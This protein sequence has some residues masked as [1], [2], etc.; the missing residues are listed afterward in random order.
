MEKFVGIELRNVLFEGEEYKSIYVD[1]ES[2]QLYY[3]ETDF[4][5][6]NQVFFQ[7]CEYLENHG[8]DVVSCEHAKI[9]EIYLSK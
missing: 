7:A 3:P 5:D 8:K 6:E 1:K 4:S 9:N 2:I